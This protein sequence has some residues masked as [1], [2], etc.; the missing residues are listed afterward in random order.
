MARYANGSIFQ[1]WTKRLTTIDPC[2]AEA[3]ALLWALE[4]ARAIHVMDIMVESDAKV[5]IDAFLGTTDY[6]PWK[7]QTLISN[8]RTL[9]LL[10]SSISVCWVSREANMVAHCL[11]KVA[12]PQAMSLLCNS[13]NLPPSVYEAWL[14][15]MSFLAF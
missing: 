13:S 12:A 1:C 3:S 8:T 14:R 9:S 7:I 15:D 10:F 6:I 5:C 4:I 2:I 11:A